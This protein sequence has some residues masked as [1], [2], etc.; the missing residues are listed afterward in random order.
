[1][2]ILSCT[3]LL[4]YYYSKCPEYEYVYKS[5]QGAVRVQTENLVNEYKHGLSAR[6][7]FNQN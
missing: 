3:H 7:T 6:M 2:S 5:I 1:M 4:I